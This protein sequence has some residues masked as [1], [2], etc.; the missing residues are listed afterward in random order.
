[1]AQEPPNW[2]TEVTEERQ[3]FTE[4]TFLTKFSSRI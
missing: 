4:Q 3:E 1:M 2:D